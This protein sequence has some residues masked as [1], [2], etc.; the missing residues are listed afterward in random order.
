MKRFSIEIQIETT[1]FDVFR[2]KLMT[3]DGKVRTF[4]SPNSI[5]CWIRSHCPE[6]GFLTRLY[7]SFTYHINE[8]K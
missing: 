8:E 6:L 4:S 3:R 7:G 1:N 5:H 2:F